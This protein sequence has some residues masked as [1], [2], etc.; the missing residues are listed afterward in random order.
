[1]LSLMAGN[2]TPLKRA[3]AIAT[4]AMVPVWM[5]VSSVQP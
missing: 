2:A 4:A 1:M 3:K 5:T